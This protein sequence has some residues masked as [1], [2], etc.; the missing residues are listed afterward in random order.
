MLDPQVRVHSQLVHNL[1]RKQLMI[2]LI[3]RQGPQVLKL[4]KKLQLLGHLHSPRPTPSIANHAYIFLYRF[5]YVNSHKKL[6]VN[7][8]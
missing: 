4:F 7:G 1:N 8:F 2:L 3:A 6:T 5:L